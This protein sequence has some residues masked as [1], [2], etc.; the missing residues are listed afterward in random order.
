ME[1]A[2][3]PA[4]SPCSDTAPCPESCPE[5]TWA[6]ICNLGSCAALLR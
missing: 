2:D 1:I 3:Y 5:A 6:A 4:G